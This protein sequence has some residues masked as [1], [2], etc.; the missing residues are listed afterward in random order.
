MERA[1][2]GIDLDHTTLNEDGQVSPRTKRVLQT[3]QAAGHVVAIV[4]GRSTRLALG[5]YRHLGLTSPMINFDGALG[6]NPH[7]SWPAAY[8]YAL[9]VQVVK[10]L[11]DNQDQLGIKALMLENQVGTWQ[12]VF[13]K[14]QMG[15]HLLEPDEPLFFPV[16]DAKL[17]QL[18]LKSEQPLPRANGL[19][20][21]VS[22]LDQPKVANFVKHQYPSAHIQVQA[23]GER[24]CLMSLALTTVDKYTGLA[25]LQSSYHIAP[26]RVYAFGDELNDFAMIAGAAHGVVM[27]NGHPKL[28]AIAD[29]I[30]PFSNAEDGLARYL[31]NE[32][33][34]T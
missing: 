8:S 23:W 34:L 15:F 4:T 9:N 20:L 3:L 28:K 31:E 11:I 5:I 18:G 2:I 13:Q 29:D 17:P 32:F 7:R 25:K 19:L 27:Q 30:T 10:D 24:S 12:L 6:F 26:D 1:L 33:K 21:Y 14:P 16:Q 22:K